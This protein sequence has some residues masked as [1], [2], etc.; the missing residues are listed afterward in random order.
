[1]TLPPLLSMV[2]LI[3]STSSS[4]VASM[5]LCMAVAV[6]RFDHQVVGVGDRRGVAQQRPRGLAEVAGKHDLAAA[7]AFAHPHLD[8]RRAEDVAGIAEGAAHLRVRRDFQVVV[9][10]IQLLQR[11]LRLRHG[12]QRR[13]VARRQPARGIA[14]GHVLAEAVEVGVFGFLFLDV[15]RVRQHHRQ[16]VAGGAGGVDRPRKPSATSRGSRPEWSIWA[17]VR[18]TKSMLRGSKAEGAAGFWRAFRGRPGTCRNR[19]ES[20]RRRLPPDS[21]SR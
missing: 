1:M 20:A 15:R 18:R 21:W 5:L 16:Q 13:R 9:D 11:G 17:W 4:C 7:R 19:P 3:A 10:R 8:D 6:G 14:L 2:S 12:I